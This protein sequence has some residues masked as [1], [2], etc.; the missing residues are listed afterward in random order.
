MIHP[1]PLIQGAPYTPSYVPPHLLG[2]ASSH[3]QEQ[4][5]LRTTR[6]SACAHNPIRGRGVGLHE[7]GRSQGRTRGSA[8]YHPREIEFLLDLVEADLPVG[9]KGWST[10][11]AKFREW[12]VV[13]EYPS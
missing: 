4:Q 2:Q 6:R 3:T 13:A 8:N 10:V 5:A 11:G 9:A 7:G 12:A 1:T